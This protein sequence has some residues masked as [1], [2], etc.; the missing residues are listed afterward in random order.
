MAKD[1][2]VQLVDEKLETLEEGFT[3]EFL[4]EWLEA[5]GQD[6]LPDD[7]LAELGIDH[8]ED[9]DVIVN[10][11]E[12]PDT[13]PVPEE[14]L[15]D[16]SEDPEELMGQ[17]Q[18]AYAVEDYAGAVLI[19][20]RVIELDPQHSEAQE[21][22][23]EANHKV[24]EHQS[25]QKLID[26]KTVLRTSQDIQKLD[27]AV[28][29]AAGLLA[30]GKGDD[31]LEQL[32]EL[33]KKT[34]DDK[35][36]IQGAG[37]TAEA[38]GEY[39][40][41]AD[42]LA[43][44][45][46]AI[47]RGEETYFDA[48]SNDVR[49]INIIYEEFSEQ[50]PS[51]ALDVMQL[52]LTRAKDQMGPHP[53]AAVDLLEEALALKGLTK[54]QKTELQGQLDATQKR[55]KK[56]QQ[57]EKALQRADAESDSIKAFQQVVK[58]R[59]AYEDYPDIGT[60][61]NSYGSQALTYLGVL[62]EQA[63][64]KVTSAL[65]NEETEALAAIASSTEAEEL[66]AFDKARKAVHDVQ[67]LAGKI[68]YENAQGDKQ[69]LM[70]RLQAQLDEITDSLQHRN[71]IQANYFKLK[72]AIDKGQTK[73]AKTI[74]NDLDVE[75][76]NDVVIKELGSLLDSVLGVDD[77]I[78]R[79]ERLLD[80]SDWQ[81]ALVELD[82]LGDEAQVVERIPQL[83]LEADI[84]ILGDQINAAWFSDDLITVQD[85]FN[86]LDRLVEK[87]LESEL[88]SKSWK[89]NLYQQ[90]HR[91]E[92]LH[93][94]EENQPNDDAAARQIND[95]EQQLEQPGF[96]FDIID[97]LIEI[98]SQPTNYKGQALRRA[99]EVKD[100]L[101]TLG[102]EELAR[103]RKAGLDDYESA[104]N[105]ANKL[106]QYDM[107]KDKQAREL[108][109][110]AVVGFYEQEHA[111]LEMFK[112]WEEIIKNW[113]NA[114]QSFKAV[115][116]LWDK[117]ADVRKACLMD[118]VD[119]ALKERQIEDALQFL[120]NPDEICVY[121]SELPFIV[122]IRA[123]Q[124]LNSRRQIAQAMMDA[125]TN[126]EQG[127][128]E[129]AIGNLDRMHQ[130]MMRPE[131]AYMRD[132]LSENAVNYL[133]EQGNIY[134]DAP[135]KKKNLPLGI[136]QYVRAL[137]IDP[138]NLLAQ[139]RIKQLEADVHTEIN[140]AITLLNDYEIQLEP[141]ET[142]LEKARG[143]EQKAQNLIKVSGL[144]TDD[145]DEGFVT[146]LQ[147]ARAKVL[148]IIPQM[149]EAR[150]QISELEADQPRW[151]GIMRGGKWGEVERSL[152]SLRMKLPA[153][154][155][156]L[157]ELAERLE[158]AR[159][160]RNKLEQA[161]AQFRSCFNQDQFNQFDE[162]RENLQQVLVEIDAEYDGEPFGIIHPEYFIVDRFVGGKIVKLDE[163]IK[164]AE[165]RAQNYSECHYW[166][167]EISQDYEAVKSQKQIIDGLRQ[168]DDS[169]YYEF[170]RGIDEFLTVAEKVI[171]RI[172]GQDGTDDELCQ[173]LS[174]KARKLRKKE[175][176]WGKEL[177]SWSKRETLNL[178]ALKKSVA[179]GIEGIGVDIVDNGETIGDMIDELIQSS[180]E[181][182]N[183][184]QFGDA[185]DMVT[186]ALNYY[187][188][189]NTPS[190]DFL[191]HLK[192]II[193]SNSK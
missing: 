153:N 183:K 176:L 68:D 54:K 110:W 167:M 117:L 71:R 47:L 96:H 77:K 181:F 87:A 104:Y 95:I 48:R 32:L 188:N 84:G 30:E 137:A 175:D 157:S 125:T 52:K 74:Y 122:D 113:E 133:L 146:K 36:A 126:N 9:E 2:L 98:S 37:T 166:H 189:A 17:A 34:R 33:G 13:S 112:N 81:E 149:E 3:K 135:G 46:A 86:Q 192:Y 15:N 177:E 16:L 184:S 28:N 124:D 66:P 82:K 58:A 75:I 116:D 127:N 22:Y 151:L 83:R 114:V 45:D 148:S 91:D 43:D 169:A 56:K 150:R 108:R 21:L 128:Y 26:L 143:D 164:I 118:Y 102:V 80:K 42:A 41:V 170:V 101:Q 147:N 161:E 121:D 88:I 51:L 53:E 185:M 12:E 57:A 97:Q 182:V 168:R 38:F 152:R 79:V 180:T 50:L 14:V 29:E 76:Q 1:N 171:V 165:Q 179:E 103:L 123:D 8:S 19:L 172:N 94:I 10:V 163:I 64:E 23:R 158:Q 78:V 130:E 18:G 5:G 44:M 11:E 55:Q 67:L 136:E 142:Q 27:N 134:V 25:H 106:Q 7:I 139:Q 193:D 70:G 159:Q 49:P 160:F 155:P 61:I 39:D 129:V 99:R 132:E 187:R 154:H 65:A 63:E 73:K 120:E 20:E 72:Q 191:T 107:V 90:L 115:K 119:E 31:D 69:A 6:D 85:Y 111:R 141:L 59:D 93:Q 144:L 162:V 89:E 100:K 62:V 174:I 173:P 24:L 140:R 138:D 178:Q 186:F 105:L 145:S 131:L 4:N 109:L 156:Q 190:K 92:R 35:K 40:A 60:Y